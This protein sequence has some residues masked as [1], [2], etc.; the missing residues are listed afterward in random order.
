MMPNTDITKFVNELDKK[1]RTNNKMI[2][3]IRM[4]NICIETTSNDFE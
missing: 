2:I 1:F 4:A 3:E